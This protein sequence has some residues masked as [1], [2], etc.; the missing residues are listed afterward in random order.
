MNE[1]LSFG[2]IAS[3]RNSNTEKLSLRLQAVKDK[4]LLRTNFLG[5]AINTIRSVGSIAFAVYLVSDR[6]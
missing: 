5:T 6:R 3:N 4:I 1:A 2:R